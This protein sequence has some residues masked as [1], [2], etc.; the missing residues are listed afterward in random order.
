MLMK[1][2][3]FLFEK[4]LPIVTD[5]LVKQIEVFKNFFTDIV[6][7]FEKIFSGDILGGIMD[8]ILGIGDAIFETIDN[9]ITAVFNVIASIFGLEGTD[10]VF[11]SI[12]GFF[13][14]IYVLVYLFLIVFCL[15]PYSMK[16]SRPG[17]YPVARPTILLL[18]CDWPWRAQT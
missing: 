11:G 17:S 12:A 16:T 3:K 2:G 15:I 14:G 10:S 5:L 13:K 7:A 4:V 8:L 6:A 1:V 18:V 9:L